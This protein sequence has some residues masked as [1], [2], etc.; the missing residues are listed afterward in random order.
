M[1]VLLS[2]QKRFGADVLSLLL[3]RGDE[4][5]GVACPRWKND[6]LDPGD[7]DS[8]PDR[9]WLAATTQGLPVIRPQSLSAETLPA[10][11]DLIVAAH[12]HAYIGRKTRLR[13][14]LGAIGYHPSL[15]PLHRG[16]DAVKWAVKMR[17]RVTGGTVYWFNNTVDGGPIAAQDFCF[18]RP[19]WGALDLW[20]E[21]L[22]PMG[23]RLLARALS[24]VDAGRIVRVPQDHSLATWEPALDPPPLFRPDLDLIGD[25]G[26]PCE[27]ITN[28][29]EL[30]RA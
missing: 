25:G 20:R 5:A 18:V 17:D 2:G 15:L 6:K 22:A 28:R 1:R 27:F 13:S 12:S 10:G 26:R 19:E 21:E 11:V 16:R 3:G 24:D 29:S 9:L 8:E 23:L 14:R 4:I 30:R 7:E